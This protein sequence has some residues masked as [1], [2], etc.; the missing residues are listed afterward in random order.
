MCMVRAN[1]C[2]TNPNCLRI[3]IMPQTETSQVLFK[4]LLTIHISNRLGSLVIIQISLLVI[5]PNHSLHL[6]HRSAGF[7][8]FILIYIHIID[9]YVYSCVCLLTIYHVHIYMFIWIRNKARHQLKII[10]SKFGKLFNV[11]SSFIWSLSTFQ[12][13]L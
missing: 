6:F 13:S 11:S 3:I 1:T 10:F 7:T 9:H 12:A 4:K 8:I 2:C 5:N